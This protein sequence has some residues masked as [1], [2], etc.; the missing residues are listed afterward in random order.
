MS[1][2]TVRAGKAYLYWGLIFLVVFGLLFGLIPVCLAPGDDPLWICMAFVALTV[3]PSLVFFLPYKWVWA[4]IDRYGITS[5]RLL[6]PTKHYSWEEISDAEI[7][8]RTGYY[9]CIIRSNGKTIAKIPRKFDGYEQMLR[10]LSRKGLLKEDAN[11][12][13]TRSWIKLSK[14]QPKD[15]LD[16]KR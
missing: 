1:T 6:R 11:L 5:H 16:K 7:D 2:L 13:R 3:S 9:P 8:G 14:M 10:I 15:L 4:D 12:R